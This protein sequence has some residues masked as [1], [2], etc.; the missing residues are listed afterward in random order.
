MKGRSTRRGDKG[1]SLV[2]LLAA[3]VI[4]ALVVALASRLFMSGQ[5]EFLARVFETDRLSALVRLKGALHQALA[6]EVV[7]CGGGKLA[8]VGD[9]AKSDLSAWVKR[10][11]PDA[12]SITFRCF[13]TN[14]GGDGLVEWKER[15]QPQL[16]EYRITLRTRGRDDR[17]EGSILK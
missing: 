9:T 7:R 2:E 12:D 15:F 8:L 17:L 16:V 10:R 14:A 11:F 6:A 5:M 4:S 1:L 3:M 13:E